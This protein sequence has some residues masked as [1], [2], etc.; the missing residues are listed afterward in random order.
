MQ[1][2]IPKACF[3]PNY[4]LV[5]SKQQFFNDEF[6]VRNIGNDGSVICKVKWKSGENER[7]ETIGQFIP[8]IAEANYVKIMVNAS[9]L[10]NELAIYFYLK[11]TYSHE[12]IQV[13]LVKYKKYRNDY[14][15]LGYEIKYYDSWTI[16]EGQEEP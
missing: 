7:E 4:V 10:T 16:D 14:H 3:V 9:A 5:G 15:T 11:N 12:Y 6:V 2:R 13:L 1:T 8:N